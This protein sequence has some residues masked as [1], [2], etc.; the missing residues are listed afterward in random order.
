MANDEYSKV[1]ELRRRASEVRTR[2]AVIIAPSGLNL[3]FFLLPGTSHSFLTLTGGGRRK[4]KTAGEV[5][6]RVNEVRT[7]ASHFFISTSSLLGL[8]NLELD[9][10]TRAQ[11]KYRPRQFGWRF[12]WIQVGRPGPNGWIVNEARQGPSTSL[13][14]GRFNETIECVDEV[15]DVRCGRRSI[16]RKWP[17][18]LFFLHLRGKNITNHQRV[19]SMNSRVDESCWIK[20]FTWTL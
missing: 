11:K 6:G 5:L 12:K 7:R 14:G 20:I 15:L 1:F 3:F 9:G 4:K 8:L 18:A 13:W 17:A 19:P 16:A 10:E 2:A